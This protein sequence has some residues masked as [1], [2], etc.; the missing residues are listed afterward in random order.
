[1]I[2]FKPETDQIPIFIK[3]IEKI[4][5]EAVLTPLD[6]GFLTRACSDIEEVKEIE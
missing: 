1:M 4:R 5:N 6:E 3:T 2:I